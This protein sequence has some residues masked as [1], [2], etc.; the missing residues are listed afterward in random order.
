MLLVWAKAAVFARLNNLPYSTTSWWGLRWGA[1]LRRERKNR[2]YLGYFRETPFFQQLIVKA[3]IHLL[4]IIKEP[5]V[6]QLSSKEVG[7]NNLYLFNQVITDEDLF[8][9]LR[10]HREVI[11]EELNAILEPAMHRQIKNY[12]PP[13][14]GVHIRRGDF[15]LGNQTTSLEYFISAI[16]LVRNTIGTILPV[17]VFTDADREEISELLLLPHILLSEDKP[18]IL[19]ILLLSKSRIMILSKSSTFGYWAAFLS[20]ALIIRPLNDWQDNIGPGKSNINYMDFKWDPTNNTATDSLSEK[21]SQLAI[22]SI[23]E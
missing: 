13:I 4:K 9:P 23:E 8:A 19:D 6:R 17:T 1:L 12:K 5:P 7:E 20:D 10:N 18:D 14:I 11:I 15:K 2:L 16:N 22:S 21:I 3:S